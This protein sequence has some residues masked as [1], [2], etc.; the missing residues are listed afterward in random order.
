MSLPVIIESAGRTNTEYSA[1]YV[2]E[3]FEQI[4][5]G[6]STESVV[7][8]VGEPVSRK[9]H[10]DYPVW[11]LR[12]EAL[13]ER[14]GKEAKIQMDGWSYS[15]PRNPRKDYELVH[16]AFGPGN[17]VIGKERWVTD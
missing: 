11:A 16:V 5:V 15:S 17:Q 13:G 12:E 9:G 14:L 4:Q 3:R 10:K 1:Q 2:E 7:E 6:M 8:L